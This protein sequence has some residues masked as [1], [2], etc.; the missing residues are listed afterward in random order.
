[1]CQLSVDVWTE[2]QVRGCLLETVATTEAFY[3]CMYTANRGD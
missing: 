2:V 1:M 3:F